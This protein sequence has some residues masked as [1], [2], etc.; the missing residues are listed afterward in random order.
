M[1]TSVRSAIPMI[2]TFLGGGSCDIKADRK[3]A[4]DIK[5]SGA[6]VVGSS[7]HL[8]LRPSPDEPLSAWSCARL[9]PFSES[10][11]AMCDEVMKFLGLF[12]GRL[13]DQ[14][15]RAHMALQVAAVNQWA[16]APAQNRDKRLSPRVICTEAGWGLP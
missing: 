5:R 16:Y 12:L 1:T 6:K 9:I 11:V 14:G 7:L 10:E 15:F 13:R 2:Q 8:Y 3:P 4:K